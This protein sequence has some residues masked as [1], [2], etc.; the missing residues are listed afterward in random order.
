MSR[1]ALSIALALL[2]ASVPAGAQRY[3]QEEARLRALARQVAVAEARLKAYDDSLARER[4]R[5]DSVYVPP[6]RMSV[7]PRFTPLARPAA[8][9]AVQRL[10]WAG[11]ALDRIAARRFVIRHDVNYWRRDSSWAYAAVLDAKGVEQWP[12]TGRDPD[13]AEVGLWLSQIATYVLAESIDPEFRAWLGV[14]PVL[15]TVPT[16][17]WAQLRLDLVS[18]P[19]SVFRACYRGDMAGCYRILGITPTTDPVREW[20]DPPA[21]RALVRQTWNKV[22]RDP[23]GIDA[24]CVA[25]NDSACV[26]VLHGSSYYGVMSASG[27]RMALLQ[28]ALQLGGPGALERMYENAASP[29]QRLERVARVPIDSL[30]RAWRTR[31]RETRTPS[32]DLTPAVGFVSLAWV[33]LFGALALRSSRWR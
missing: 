10:Q 14:Q 8:E 18:S 22:H 7:A 13:G 31:V 15:D 12:V 16:R 2:A 1:R 28:L 6:F 30:T 17:A 27:H 23:W 19:A 29:V 24:H 32:E 25:G 11:S 33:G 3:P 26:E 4:N 5:F 21:R 9:A 20:F